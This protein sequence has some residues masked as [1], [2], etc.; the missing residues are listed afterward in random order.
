[1]CSRP[2]LRTG[3]AAWLLAA[4]PA[5]AQAPTAADARGSWMLGLGAQADED[6]GD[7]V[8]GTLFVGVGSSTWLTL[9]AGQSSSPAD[10]ADLLSFYREAQER[11]GLDHEGAVREA[12]V[13]VLTS[14]KFSYRVDLVEARGGIQPLS[15][16]DLASRLSYFLWSSMP[17]EELLKHAAA[18]DLRRPEVIR[19]QARRM[20]Q[21]RRVR[22]LAVEFG[23]N[24]LD[25][26]PS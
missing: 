26:R 2:Y 25:F 22:A 16:Y 12:I 7:S 9:A 17:D 10:R 18:G 23:G 19:A 6:D 24:W 3:L 8:L 15:D 5:W 11:Y 4:T 14:P 20:L 1:M 13:L 21:N